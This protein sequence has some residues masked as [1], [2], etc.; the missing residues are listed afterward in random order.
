MAS[1][2]YAT[3]VKKKGLSFDRPFVRYLAPS[4]REDQDASVP[5]AV[6]VAIGAS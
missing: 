5:E 1:Y 4:Q 2:R 6:G 3:A